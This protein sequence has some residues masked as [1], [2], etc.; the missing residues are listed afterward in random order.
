MPVDNTFPN[1]EPPPHPEDNSV[2]KNAQP[3][4]V[5]KSAEPVLIDPKLAGALTDE[6]DAIPQG[7]QNVSTFNTTV[8]EAVLPSG[9]QPQQLSREQ[10]VSFISKKGPPKVLLIVLGA[11]LLL[12]IVTMVMLFLRREKPVSLVGTKGELTWWGVD[13]DE[14][15]VKPI[16]EDYVNKNP[17]VKINYI[18]QSSQDY[19]ERLTNAL[20]QGKGPDIFEIHNSWVPMFKTELSTLPANIMSSDDYKKTFYPVAVQDFTTT[21]GIVAIPL[22]YDALTLFYNQDIFDSAA[23]KPPTTWD[24]LTSLA[25][26]LTQNG[27]GKGVI[28]QS[29][30]AL[31]ITDNIDYWPDILGLMVIQNG[32]DPGKPNQKAWDALAFYASFAQ[33]HPVWNSSMPHSTSAF[34]KNKV[35]MIFAPTAATKDIV[36]E[37]SNLRFKTATIPQLPKNNPTDPDYSYAT[38]WAQGVWV[39][40]KNTSVAWDFLKY[41][42]NRE[43]LTKMNETRKNINVL[44]KAYPRRD[45]AVLQKEDKIF[46][47]VLSLAENSRSWYLHDKTSDGLTGLNSQMNEIYKNTLNSVIDNK[48]PDKNIDPWNLGITGVIAK[49]TAKKK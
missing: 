6:I 26:N 15:V 40:S 44:Q 48:D 49:Y 25:K 22:E 36:L 20:A 34:A 9:S 29:G 7:T 18:K 42:S 39:R 31:G 37:N 24:D 1:T 11:F 38:Y 14:S 27:E 21:S 3:S 4:G 35:A 23:L 41:L 30:V 2:D 33:D 43:S 46:G 16:I 8:P 32:S 17:N 10:T 45:M 19:R 28:L 5:T 47:P 12:I 13:N